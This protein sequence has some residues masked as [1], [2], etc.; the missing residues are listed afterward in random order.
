MYFTL[1][2]RSTIQCELQRVS[3]LTCEQ[4]KQ[5]IKSDLHMLMSLM[6]TPQQNISTNMWQPIVVITHINCAWYAHVQYTLIT[7]SSQWVTQLQCVWS[8]LTHMSLTN[9]TH[10]LRLNQLNTGIPTFFHLG[11]APHSL[12]KV[13]A[14]AMTHLK[15]I[16]LSE[17]TDHNSCLHTLSQKHT[18]NNHS[19]THCIST[20]TK[21]KCSQTFQLN[22]NCTNSNGSC[23]SSKRERCSSTAAERNWS[24]MIASLATE[25]KVQNIKSQ[26]FRNTRQPSELL[27]MSPRGGQTSSSSWRNKV[28]TLCMYICM[29]VYIYS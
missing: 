4:Y 7:T 15:I 9:K 27:I 3:L 22:W 19:N 12:N 5:W 11:T 1:L 14:Q 6:I 23:K 29:Y 8:S 25:H 13:C 16:Q 10:Q 18:C 24:F 21:L 20:L 26:N 17:N 2:L 28:Q